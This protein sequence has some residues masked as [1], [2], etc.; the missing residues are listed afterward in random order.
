MTIAQPTHIL[1]LENNP[2][3]AEIIRR[4]FDIR[5][6]TI[7]F[8]IASTLAEG[9]SI[10]ESDPP[11]LIIAN[12]NLP[13]G[14]GIELLSKRSN[15]QDIAV[16]IMANSGNERD[17]IEAIK[18]GALDYVVMTAQAL[19]AMPRIADRVIRQWKTRIEKARI[20]HELYLRAEAE[21]I[22][23]TIGQT[24]ISNQTLDQVLTT[25]MTI[26]KQK[27][28]V[29]TGTILL[30]DT[31][32]ERI[33]F[34]KLLQGNPETFAAF[35]LKKG[36]GVVGWVIENARTALVPDVM[37]D[38]RWLSRI[39]QK[40]GFVTRS[41][42]CVPLIAQN[43]VIG[44]IELLNKSQGT[45]DER[46]A[47]ILESI[48][49]PLAIAI[50]NARLKEQVQRQLTELTQVFA[51][52]ENAKHEWEQTVDGIDAGIW[53]V[54]ENCR[55]MRANR[56]LANWVGSTPNALT[57]QDCRQAIG[58]CAAYSDTCPVKLRA[59]DVVRR[60]ENQV[61][62]LGG[63]TFRLDTYPTLS[64]GNLVGGVNV[65]LDITAEK[66]MQSQLMQAEKLAGIGRLAASL[67]HEINNPLQALQGCL[68][69]V[70][71]N[72]NNLEKQ[73]RYLGIAKSE[74]ERLSVMVQRMLDFYRPSKG[75]RGAMDIKA[76]LDEVLALSD[77]RLQ[78]ARVNKRIQWDGQIPILY[79]VANQ[80]K[81][82]FLNLILNA[83]DAMPN[84][85]EIFIH[86]QVVEPGKQFRVDFCDSGAGIAPEHIDK[87]F[88]PFY[89]TK[90]T[91]TGLGLGIS[92]T[93]IMSHGGRLTVESSVGKGTTM[94]VWLPIQ[95]T[96]DG[97]LRISEPD[98]SDEELLALEQKSHGQI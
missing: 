21:A 31:A 2:A 89:T 91:G 11:H 93:I 13:D 58:V 78:H 97:L 71:A 16:V 9:R 36:E 20:E 46:D 6:A 66:A 83:T 14:E 15:A 42:L 65:L 50:Q 82:V 41:I 95:P 79:G 3:H 51:K 70:Q 80:I 23:S 92:H 35:S 43:E 61:P 48:A 1:L 57:G 90:P 63:G 34:A 37:T 86:G 29:D 59:T 33:V 30:W 39:D 55:I 67:A 75:V 94:S 45:F 47:Q 98:K 69:L 27:M 10:V 77:K 73:Q 74:V 18:A 96:P 26:V 81:Q 68:D 8:S 38:P 76:L 64:G 22:W 24:I 19:S 60:G 49:A 87:V 85:G 84:G 44:A 52:V 56:I 7:R 88:E 28:Q 25:V 53:L 5:G 17:A 4:A 40:T 72:P 54:D 62:N 32:T 12:W